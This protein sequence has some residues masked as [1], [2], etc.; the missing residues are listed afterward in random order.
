MK[1]CFNFLVIFISLISMNCANLLPTGKATVK[2]PWTDFHSCRLDYEKITP[3][4]TTVAELKKMGLDPYAVPNIRIMNATDVINVFMPTPSIRKEDLDPGI[5][6]C[7]ESKDRCTAYQITPS[8]LEA[9]R[10]GNFWLDLFSFKRETISTGWEFRGLITIV[11]AVV[12]YRDPVGGRP[13][14]NTE[15]IQTKPL[16][17]LQDAGNIIQSVAP[18]YI[19]P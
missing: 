11:D 8:N 6:K 7:I 10:T 3:G 17:P 16:G 19:H 1:A 12:T 2:S 5:Q 14:I 15:D 18:A 13:F 9:K 4:I